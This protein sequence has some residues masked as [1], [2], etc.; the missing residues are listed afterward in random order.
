[1]ELST[2]YLNL[3]DSIQKILKQNNYDVNMVTSSPKANSFYKGGLVKKY[4]PWIYRYYEY[5]LLKLFKKGSSKNFDLYEYEKKGW[6]YHAKG[7]WLYE[8]NK[9]L[10]NTTV[11]GSSNYSKFVLFIAIF[12]KYLRFKII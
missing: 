12:I 3:P 1:M 6:T 4:I 5:L 11:I 8:K 2:G 9:I 7:I 10:P